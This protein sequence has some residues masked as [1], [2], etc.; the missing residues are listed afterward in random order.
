MG[1]DKLFLPLD[2]VPVLARTLRA[3][4]AAGFFKLHTRYQNDSSVESGSVI[5]QSPEPSYGKIE[6]GSIIKLTVSQGAEPT[7]TPTPTPVPATPTPVPA[8]PT[9]VPAT[10]TPVPATP[11][12]VPATPT[13]PPEP[14]T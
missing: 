13:T 11:T 12:P 7:A 14:G 5:S 4:N 1:K 3:L 6:K 10:P 2:G 8:T 9:P